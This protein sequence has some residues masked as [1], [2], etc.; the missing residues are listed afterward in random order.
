[1]EIT[2]MNIQDLKKKI[3]YPI[4]QNLRYIYSRVPLPI[5]Y[6]KVFR[7]TYAFLQKSQWWSREQLEE[8]QLQQLEKLLSHAYENVPYY[9]RI[10]DDRGLKPKDIKSIDD[11]KKLPYLTKDII[12]ENLSDLIAQNYP[13]SKLQYVT[14]GGSTGIPMGL[15]WEKGLT[16]PKESAFVWRQWNWAG[17]RFGEKR[18]ILRGNVINRFKDGKRQWWEYNSLYN[19]LILSSFDMTEENLPKYIEKIYKFKPVAIQG[20]P[21]SLAILANFLKQE[22]LRLEGINCV[23]TSSESLYQ[24]QRKMVEEYLGAE[25]FDHYGN[26]ERNALIMQC[27]KGNYHIISEYGIV[28][29]MGKGSHLVGREGQAGEIIATGFNNYAMPFIRYRTMDLGVYTNQE[30]SC[31]RN[32]PLLKRFGGRMQEYFVDKT[33]SLITFIYSDVA[34]WNV[35]DKINGYQYVQDEPGKVLLSIDAKT[36]FAISDTESVK[37]SFGEYYSRFDIEIKF[38]ENIPRTK[39]GKFRFLIQKL[40]IE[41]GEA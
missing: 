33:G 18:A 39:S 9:K 34:L 14:T 5:R 2:S 24:H 12:R 40:P 16:D 32:Y 20:Y 38:V 10:F 22:N 8:Y 15:Y 19:A 29:L 1:M 23:L 11:L 27:E 31:G 35:K 41:F 25:I 28:E 3:T 30:C 37:R 36:K 13:K 17:Y 21:S 4:K 7:K 26:S 6:G